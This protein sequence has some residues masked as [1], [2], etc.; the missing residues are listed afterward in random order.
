M[1]REEIGVYPEPA[2]RRRKRTPWVLIVL[3]VVAGLAGAHVAGLTKPL[4]G[5]AA[6]FGLGGARNMR[7][8]SDRLVGEWESEDDPMF[9]H[10]CHVARKKG[11][12]GTGLYV[13]YAGS[14]MTEVTYTVISEDRSG[15]SLVTSEYLPAVNLNIRTHYSVAKDGKSMTREYNRG[16]TH[17]TSRYR[18]VGPPTV[19]IPGESP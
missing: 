10:V 11:R 1:I 6:Q 18:Y 12:G 3:V 16:D 2:C 14:G 13:A 4:A 19:A 9:Q 5:V 8:P 17:V 7:T 15:T